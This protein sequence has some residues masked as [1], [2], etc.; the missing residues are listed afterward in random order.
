M[1]DITNG[2][3]KVDKNAPRNECYNSYVTG[4]TNLGDETRGRLVDSSRKDSRGCSPDVAELPS[5]EMG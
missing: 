1:L 4:H 3:S 5:D 2:E